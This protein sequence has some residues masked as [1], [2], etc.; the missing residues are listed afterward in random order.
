MY[1]IMYHPQQPPTRARAGPIRGR[2]PRRAA[3]APRR[4]LSC[5][6]WFNSAGAEERV[7]EP[8]KAGEDWADAMATCYGHIA[9]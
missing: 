8:C 9:W 5:S 6:Q 3:R 7:C 2:R 1:N 4:C